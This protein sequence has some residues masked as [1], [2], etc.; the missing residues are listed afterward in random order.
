MAV[1]DYIRQCKICDA[2]F[3]RTAKGQS[4]KYCSDQCHS[5]AYK[6]QRQK[7][8]ARPG[9]KQRVRE[10]QRLYRKPQRGPFVC[11][12][13]GVEYMTSR[14]LGEGERYCSRACFFSADSKAARKA[15]TKAS[16]LLRVEIAAL[17][18]IGNRARMGWSPYAHCERC[19]KKFRSHGARYC[20]SQCRYFVNTIRECE[21]CGSSYHPVGR[22]HI[23]VCSVACRDARAAA[24]H[25][26]YL[27]TEPYKSARRA[28]K[29]RRSARRRA[30]GDIKAQNIDPLKVFARDGWRCHLCGHSTPRKLRGTYKP[31]AP[32]LDHIV[33]LADG[34]HHTWTNV[35]CACRQCNAAKGATSRGQLHIGFAA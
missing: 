20:S 3:R 28:A 12:G 11:A 24:T 27:Q 29:K 7:T 15:A 26:R 17:L 31:R 34:G 1:L 25:A 8:E 19:G 21:A 5:T 22:V 18:R 4:V 13:C 10:R 32:E 16:I 35:A 30:S 23:G 33:T 9:H 6:Q 14:K 2:E